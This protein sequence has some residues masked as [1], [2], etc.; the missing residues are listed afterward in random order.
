MVR[1]Y[2]ESAQQE[3]EIGPIEEREKEIFESSNWTKV[4]NCW[5]KKLKK[6]GSPLESSRLRMMMV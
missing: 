5:R 1:R 4:H 3:K 2:D 6:N